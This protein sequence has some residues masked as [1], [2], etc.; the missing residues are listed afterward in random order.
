MKAMSLDPRAVIRVERAFVMEA[1]ASTQ[2]FRTMQNSAAHSQPS[3][4][5]ADRSF[6]P[7]LDKGPKFEAYY[8]APAESTRRSLV[9]A[10]RLDQKR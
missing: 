7:Q 10:R 1:L 4:K 3:R 6:E 8:I 9:R 2:A 5:V